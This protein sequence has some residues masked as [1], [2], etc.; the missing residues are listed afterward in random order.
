MPSST[1][2]A[3]AAMSADQTV[4]QALH[5]TSRIRGRL[6]ALEAA[7]AGQ[8]AR[9]RLRVSVELGALIEELLSITYRRPA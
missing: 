5:L 2:L 7:I 3:Q 6:D 9:G 1:T 8:D 4:G